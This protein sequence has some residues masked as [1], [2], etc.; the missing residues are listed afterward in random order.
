MFFA[1]TGRPLRLLA[2]FA[3][4]PGL[5]AVFF[6]PGLRGLPGPRPLRLALAASF[7]FA[8]F[9]SARS[10]TFA[11]LS[12]AFAS[13]FSTARWFAAFALF[14]AFVNAATSDNNESKTVDCFGLRPL[15]TPVVLFFEPGFLPLFFGAA[16]AAGLAAALGALAFGLRGIVIII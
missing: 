16:T 7:T 11:I 6:G 3:G 14:T 5:R 15:F 8:I 13:I 10:F 1:P 2:P 12:S 9:F 4:R